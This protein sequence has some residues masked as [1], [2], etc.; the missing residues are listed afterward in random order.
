MATRNVT[1]GI[2]SLANRGTDCFLVA[3]VNVIHAVTPFMNAALA[4]AA[5]NQMRK[6]YMYLYTFFAENVATAAMHRI[7]QGEVSHVR[8]LRIALGPQW[9]SGQQEDSAEVFF[10][11]TQDMSGGRISV[12]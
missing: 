1:S 3:A 9:D 4:H 2:L 8:D 12:G 7:L 10:R 11:L 6:V 5:G